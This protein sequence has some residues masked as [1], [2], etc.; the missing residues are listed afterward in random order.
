MSGESNRRPRGYLPSA[1][2]RL[3]GTDPDLL[4]GRIGLADLDRVPIRRAPRWMVKSW[5]KDVAAMTLPWAIYVDPRTLGGDPAR[6]GRLIEHELVHVR[7]WRELGTLSFLSH[8]L[9]DYWAGRRR[10]LDHTEAYLAISLEKEARD[11]VGH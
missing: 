10:G 11:I 2:A 8:Y 5:R 6:L 1:V 3:G 4:A 9:R 7:Q